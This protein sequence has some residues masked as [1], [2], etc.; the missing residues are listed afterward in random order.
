MGNKTIKEMDKSLRPRE[1]L[2]SNGVS[3]L[4]DEELLAIFIDNGTKSQNAIET[5]KQLID[6]A[7]DLSNLAKFDVNMMTKIKGIGVAKACKIVSAIEFANRVI[8]NSA[9]KKDESITSPKQLI[10]MF[11]VEFE[12]LSVEVFKIICLDTKKHITYVK[13]LSIGIANA[14]TITARE[15]FKEAILR[16]AVSVIVMH[17]HPSKNS[18]PS[19]NDIILTR[20]L[21]E[22]GRCLDIDLTDHIIYGSVENHYSFRENNTI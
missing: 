22:A 6:L 21:A 13:N 17:N 4:S 18:M 3:T 11:S 8:K 20:K 14:T 2:L 19:D 7:G 15:V 16:H 1:K 12:T 5:A 10:D 9:K